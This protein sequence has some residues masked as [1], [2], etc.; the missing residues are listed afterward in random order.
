MFKCKF[1]QIDGHFEVDCR[2]KKSESKDKSSDKDRASKDKDTVTLIARTH[3]YCMYYSVSIVRYV[4][5]DR[6]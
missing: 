4:L 3:T 6:T 1:C 2:K 5:Y